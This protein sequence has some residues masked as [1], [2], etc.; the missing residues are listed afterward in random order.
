MIV[1]EAIFEDVFGIEQTLLKA[2]SLSES[3]VP[4]VE[5]PYAY[6]KL[7]DLIARRLAW[8]A[9]DASHND[10]IVGCLILDHHYWPWNRKEWF[11]VN[12]H[13]WVDPKHRT[14]G[15]AAKFLACAKRC[16]T[17]TGRR[18][19]LDLSFGGI[20]AE[21]KDRFVRMQGFEYVGGR[22]SF[23]PSSSSALAAE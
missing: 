10:K 3:A 18:V 17:E 21:L 20:D 6:Q 8:V 4:P 13:Y 5:R 7:M 11:L 22:F 12:D 2:A 14:G 9:V 15:I 19:I 1:R 23:S 16:A